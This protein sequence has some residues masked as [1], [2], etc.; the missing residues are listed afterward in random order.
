MVTATTLG[1]FCE[2]LSVP[3]SAS[4]SLLHGRHRGGHHILSFNSQQPREH[5]IVTAVL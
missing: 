1:E 5:E 4:R 3:A 2:H